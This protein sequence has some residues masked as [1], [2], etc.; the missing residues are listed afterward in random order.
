MKVCA[1]YAFATLTKKVSL[2]VC[3]A[4]TNSAEHAGNT[5]SKTKCKKMEQCAYSAPALNWDVMWFFHTQL[6]S[7]S[8]LTK[9]PRKAKPTTS[10]SITSGIASNSQMRTRTLSGVLPK[11]V[12]T[13]LKDLST[14][15]VILLIVN[16]GKYSASNVALKT[17]SQQV[18]Q[19]SSFGQK[20]NKMILK[21]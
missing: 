14:P 1:K 13:L 6:M 18:V 19:L 20:R 5:S 11:N 21:T 12:N 15:I 4:A 3:R 9:C 8:Y 7:L 16:A 2:L 17:T 10:R